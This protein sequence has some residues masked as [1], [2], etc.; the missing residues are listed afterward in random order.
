MLEKKVSR[1]SVESDYKKYIPKECI[2]RH[3]FFIKKPIHNALA[4]LSGHDASYVKEQYLKQFEIMAPNYPCEEHKALL[5]KG[6]ENSLSRV[7]LR[8]NADRIDYCEVDEK[9]ITLCTIE[10][11]C[12]V[13]IR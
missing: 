3:S 12:T 1:E 9:W 4:R 7:V 2:K 13:S 8:V 6:I 5:Q 11:L 10:D